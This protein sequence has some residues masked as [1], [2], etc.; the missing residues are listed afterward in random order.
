MKKIIWLLLVLLFTALFSQ[1]YGQK[2]YND[3][4]EKEQVVLIGKIESAYLEFNKKLID[5]NV[6][7]AYLEE[8]NPVVE[9]TGLYIEIGKKLIRYYAISRKH[10]IQIFEL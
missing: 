6:L 1:L 4:T 10:T 3:L 8:N 2:T 7:L 9:F 5:T